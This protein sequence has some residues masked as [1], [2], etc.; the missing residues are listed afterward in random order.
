MRFFLPLTA[1]I[2]TFALGVSAQQDTPLLTSIG[3]LDVEGSL[4]EAHFDLESKRVWMAVYQSNAEKRED[5]YKI[6]AVN[7]ETGL[8]D[9]E[10]AISDYISSFSPCI[11]SNQLIVVPS[12]ES[13]EIISIDGNVISTLPSKGGLTY[14]VQISP[15]GKYIAVQSQS[16][17]IVY[18]TVFEN[19]SKSKYRQLYTITSGFFRY[20]SANSKYFLT[21]NES[22]LTINDALSG[23]TARSYKFDDSTSAKTSAS[24]FSIA[25]DATTTAVGYKNGETRIRPLAGLNPRTMVVKIAEGNVAALVSTND[26]SKYVAGADGELVIVNAQSGVV[27]GRIAVA[28]DQTPSYLEFSRDGQYLLALM[29][30]KIEVFQVS[31]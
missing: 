24:S 1:L 26:G 5:R 22:T 6:R 30:G 23:K 7:L 2:F 4:T 19:N 10:V 13:A 20:W 25:G 21:S 8:T 15:D 16:L 31:R 11:G 9:A 3:I 12:S 28:S 18:V 29:S 27:E 14:V 17:G